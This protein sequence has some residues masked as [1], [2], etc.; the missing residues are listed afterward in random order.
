MLP[1]EKIMC[2]HTGF[3]K[4]CFDLVTQS[5]CRKWRNVL[6]ANPQTGE[7]MNIWDCIEGLQHQIQLDTGR[8]VMQMVASLDKLAT[9]VSSANDAGMAN[10]L[11]GINA[12]VRR[13]AEINQAQVDMFIS[14][15]RAP[16]PKLIG[17][18]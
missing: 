10:A 15:D 3:E 16:Q 14:D 5:K 6:G 8:A 7:Q 18:N 13:V 11:M 12:Q 2:H 9:E 4:R 17:S 1:D